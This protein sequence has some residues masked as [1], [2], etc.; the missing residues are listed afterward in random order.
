MSFKRVLIPAFAAAAALVSQMAAATAPQSCN[1]PSCTTAGVPVTFQVQ[2]PGVM[3]LEVGATAGATTVT[4]DN[5]VITAANVGDSTA[6]NPS[7]IANAGTGATGNQVYYRVLSNLGGTNVQVNAANVGGLACS[8]GGCGAD[9]IAI[10]QI[11]TG[12]TGT[13]AHPTVNGGATLVPY[14]GTGIIN[15]TGFWTYQYSNATLPLSGTYTG[16]ITYT[17]TDN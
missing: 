17:V 11:A 1:T 9:S 12:N 7:G 15:E 10:T 5:T 6:V 8:A 3:R 2:I 14:P 13:V 16:T 4:W